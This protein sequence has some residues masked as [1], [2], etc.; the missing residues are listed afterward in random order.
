MM[1]SRSISRNQLLHCMETAATRALAAAPT[2]WLEALLLLPLLLLLHITCGTGS[3][4]TPAVCH[5]TC[6]RSKH[7]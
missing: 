3:R 6:D 2:A 7:G 5:G 1:N 4:C